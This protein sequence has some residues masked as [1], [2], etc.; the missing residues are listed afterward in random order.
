[1]LVCP[2]HRHCSEKL[3]LVLRDHIQRK[4]WF[5]NE[6]NK[7]TKKTKARQKKTKKQTK[8]NVRWFQ[9]RTFSFFRPF[10]VTKPITRTF[11]YLPTHVLI[12]SVST[13]N[14]VPGTRTHPNFV[15]VSVYRQ[16]ILRFRRVKTVDWPPLQVFPG[17]LDLVVAQ[18]VFVFVQLFCRM[19]FLNL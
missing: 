5:S 1:M 12:D 6:K 18:L 4:F 15:S 7:M 8:N 10:C 3:R 17:A 13:A 11:L 9:S 19:H 16:E 2:R 14:C